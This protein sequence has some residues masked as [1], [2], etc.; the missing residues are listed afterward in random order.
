M[1]QSGSV[2]QVDRALAAVVGAINALTERQDDGPGV[3]LTLGGLVVSGTVVP[4]WQW[5]DEV[6]HAARAA[7]VVHTGGSVDDEHGGWASLFEGVAESLVQARDEHRAAREATKHL[8]DRYQRLL[9]QQDRTTY[10]HLR[11][12]RVVAADASPLPVAGM[13]WRG[14]LSEVSGWSFGHVGAEPPAAAA[15]SKPRNLADDV[16][17]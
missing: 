12:A 11:E 13:H 9:A 7:F 8:T 1:A 5:F 16:R 2:P 3:F 6:E 17:G 10:I 4:D 15:Q 14:R